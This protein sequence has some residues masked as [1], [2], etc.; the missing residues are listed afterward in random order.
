MAWHLR[1]KSTGIK[2]LTPPMPVVPL[3]PLKAIQPL[4]PIKPVA[5]LG[6]EYY[7][8]DNGKK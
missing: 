4:R 7:W 8:R 2:P 1:K 3:K 5:P 6:Q